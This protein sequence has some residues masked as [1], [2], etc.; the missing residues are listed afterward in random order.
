MGSEIS[1]EERGRAAATEI[2]MICEKYGVVFKPVVQLQ[3]KYA[4]P[5]APASEVI[6][7]GMRAPVNETEILPDSAEAGNK[8]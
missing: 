3:D 8:N 5:D 2:Q 1:Y 7:A 4:T 6:S